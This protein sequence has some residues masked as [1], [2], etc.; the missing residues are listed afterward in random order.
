M[1]NGEMLRVKAQE[2]VML[3][4]VAT[5]MVQQKKTEQAQ[6]ILG[7]IKSVVA[8]IHKDFGTGLT[9]QNIDVVFESLVVY[10][11]GT[12]F[13]YRTLYDID[14]IEAIEYG[15]YTT[16][17]VA[18]YISG[19]ERFNSR[20]LPESVKY[21]ILTLS[22]GS[23]LVGLFSKD[24]VKSN[25]GLLSMGEMRQL[26]NAFVQSYEE[27]RVVAADSPLLKVNSELYQVMSQ[28]GRESEI[29]CEYLGDILRS[30]ENYIRKHPLY[31][32][33]ADAEARLSKFDYIY[34]STYWARMEK[35]YIDNYEYLNFIFD[36]Y[37]PYLTDAAIRNNARLCNLYVKN[38]DFS[39]CDF[40]ECLFEMYEDICRQMDVEPMKHHK[41]SLA[42]R[43][44]FIT[45]R[46]L[47]KMH[48]EVMKTFYH[49]REYDL[50]G[51]SCLSDKPDVEEVADFIEKKVDDDG[52]IDYL[53][54]LLDFIVEYDGT[55]I[56]MNLLD[57]HVR[58][59][60]LT[61]NDHIQA[62]RLLR[63]KMDAALGEYTAA[64]KDA[65]ILPAD[66]IFKC[67]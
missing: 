8:A 52:V 44:P 33:P 14:A 24:M 34:N 25:M 7:K 42:E 61:N 38:P 67:E 46:D 57:R 18:D 21:S 5:A 6:E 15:I 32:S 11:N 62:A 48:R 17:I 40:P 65:G 63:E 9:P 35:D 16:R 27:L 45:M 36:Q 39:W 22:L 31:S 58:I 56:L 12:S 50:F 41:L 53:I 28:S 23:L 47:E 10:G 37:R 3:Q 29:S 51:M 2:L 66:W 55:V 49:L 64:L 4:R 1:I 20:V 59:Y 26:Q 43:I 13:V 19:I 54:A 30:L 60:R